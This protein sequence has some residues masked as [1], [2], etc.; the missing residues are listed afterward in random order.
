MQDDGKELAGRRVL[1]VEDESLVAMDYCNRL[2]AAGAEI[3]GPFTSV[4]Q[5]LASLEM[6]RIDV[7][8]L[9]HALADRNSETLQ[10]A[11]E[12]RDIPFVIITG[13]P[14][15]LVRREAQQNVLSK[16]VSADALCTAIRAACR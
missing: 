10:G 7:A 8:V 11:L 9:D 5:A 16:P 6:G 3:V 12:A 4:A 13:Y 14:R 1:V 2:S 15:V